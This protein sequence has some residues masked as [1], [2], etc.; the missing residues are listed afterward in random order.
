MSE[1]DEEGA[2]EEQAGGGLLETITDAGSDLAESFDGL[3][4]QVKKGIWKTIQR[5]GTAT[6]ELG[7]AKID[8]KTAEIEAVT[9]ARTDITEATA[10]KIAENARVPQEYVDAAIHQHYENIIGRK[11]TMDEVVSGAIKMTA[12]KL[13]QLPSDSEVLADEESTIGDEF[14]NEFEQQAETKTT[15]EMKAMFS[16]LLSHEIIQ[17]GSVSTKTIKIL[18]DMTPEIALLFQKF[19]SLTTYLGMP[20]GKPSHDD[21][22]I[23]ATDKSASQN[24]L[25]QYGL[26]YSTLC[27]LADYGL[28]STEFNSNMTYTPAVV[29][30]NTVMFAL[31]HQS[32]NWVLKKIDEEKPVDVKLSGVALAS[33][34]RE[35]F[36]IVEL[37]PNEEYLT[38]LKEYLKKRNVT[39]QGVQ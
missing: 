7:V 34:G 21:I 15:E 4:P 9:K 20:N 22:R 5:F 24:G 35:L 27:K 1:E 17:P 36:P 38:D 29:T 30:D 11:I 23:V 39:I 12:E 13:K 37:D 10:A 25:Q 3:P 28:I 2:P 33:V 18:G 31:L 16:A 6:L 14:L 26:G 8:G 19:C 32:K